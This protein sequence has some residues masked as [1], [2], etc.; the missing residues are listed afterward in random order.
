MTENLTDTFN[1]LPE[2]TGLPFRRYGNRMISATYIN[3]DA[4]R[5]KDK[6]WAVLKSKG[7]YIAENGGEN[8]SLREWLVKYGDI[9]RL[10]R[11]SKGSWEDV[12][13]PKQI[14]VTD[15]MVDATIPDKYKG[16][17]YNFLS[18]AFGKREVRDMLWKYNVGEGSEGETIFWYQNAIGK[19]C[20]DQRILYGVNGRRQKDVGGWRK[21][22]VDMGYTA[23]CVF[24]AHLIG[25]RDDINV[26]ESE[27]TALIMA[28]SGA[29]GVWVATGG[30]T[31]LGGIRDGWKLYPDYDEAGKLWEKKGEVV[32]WWEGEEVSEG[33]DI[34]DL[35]VRKY[36]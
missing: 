13:P 32:K 28:L 18:F 17:L 30:S 20:H 24:G 2:I 22:K 15:E 12:K 26:V 16:N 10:G 19:F 6:T 31:K 23:K 34:G 36:L 25:V 11:R 5:Q 29:D 4:H 8:I 21:H 7:I 1:S 35:V 9:T 27:K 3:G 33:E 14:W